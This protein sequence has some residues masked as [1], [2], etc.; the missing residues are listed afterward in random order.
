MRLIVELLV[1]VGSIYAAIIARNDRHPI[2]RRLSPYGTG[3]VRRSGIVFAIVSS[4]FVIETIVHRVFGAP[5]LELNIFVIYEQNDIGAVAALSICIF[6]IFYI[7][8][9]ASLIRTGHQ[10]RNARYFWAGVLCVMAILIIAV[11]GIFRDRT[12]VDGS[13]SFPPIADYNNLRGLGDL[14]LGNDGNFYAG[15]EYKRGAIFRITPSGALMVLYLFSSDENGL[16]PFSRLILG[17]DGHFYGTTY[18]GGENDA[19]TVFKVTLSGQLKVLHSFER[20]EDRVAF[21]PVLEWLFQSGALPCRSMTLGADGNFYGTTLRGDG[22]GT[23]YGITPKGQFTTLHSFLAPTAGRVLANGALPASCLTVG[24]DGYLYGATWAGGDQSRNM[25]GNGTVFKISTAGELT[26]LHS[27]DGSDGSAPN[28]LTLGADG[29]LYGTTL[30]GGSKHRGTVFKI[31]P[32]GILTTLHSFG[33][34]D[35]TFPGTLTLGIDGSFYG[36]TAGLSASTV[37]KITAAGELTTVYHGNPLLNPTSLVLG[38]DGNFYGTGGRLQNRGMVFK[39]TPAGEL[40]FL[41]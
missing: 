31:T 41:F 4:Y 11:I 28:T 5:E 39:I 17:R 36:V 35:G 22:A 1:L 14:T 32:G 16:P 25:T 10:Q 13:S 23:E 7:L 15:G 21:V 12:L 40:T 37:F 6:A 19:G 2:F 29:N 24:K 8:S 33:G 3:L 38:R 9:P 30:E 34:S 20:I 26:T 18:S 27:F